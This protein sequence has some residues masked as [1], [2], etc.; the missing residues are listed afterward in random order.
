MSLTK[1]QLDAAAEVLAEIEVTAKT[2]RNMVMTTSDGCV[3]H[4]VLT[5]EQLADLQTRYVNEKPN[6]VNLYNQLPG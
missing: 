3:D 5:D 2:L 4:I 1:E 6:L